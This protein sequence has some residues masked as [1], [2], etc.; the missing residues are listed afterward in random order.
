MLQSDVYDTKEIDNELFLSSIPLTLIEEAIKSQFDDPL[1]Y[2]KTDYIQSFLNKYQFSIDNMY[3]EDQ[4]ELNELHDDFIEFIKNIFFEYLNIGIPNIEDKPEEEQHQIIHYLY[5]YFITNI[6]KNFT[7][8]IINYIEK[9][10]DEISSI[11]IKKKDVIYLN[12]KNEI[13]DE[14]DV[15]LLSNL[16]LII[17]HI[18][19]E[20]YDVDNFFELTSFDELCVELEFVKKSFDD[21]DLTGNFIVPYISMV[22]KYFR[23]ELESKI[24]NK[25]L[26]KYPKRRK[27]LIIE[28]D[29]SEDEVSNTE[30]AE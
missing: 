6:K 27:E 29:E 18:L 1:E 12:F 26:K 13:S 28:D 21:F 4:L 11:C 5:R 2:R 25:I 10:K 8:L 9:N 20:E 15:L 7:N 3:E 23:T 30:S 17:E 16:S 14:F 19:T 22:D 24:R